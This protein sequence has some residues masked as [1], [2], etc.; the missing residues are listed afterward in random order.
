MYQTFFTGVYPDEESKGQ[1]SPLEVVR[2]RGWRG[3][4]VGT[5]RSKSLSDSSPSS[6]DFT[7]GTGKVIRFRVVGGTRSRVCRDPV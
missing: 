4:G 5:G 2:G 7:S 6:Q 3:G 1:S